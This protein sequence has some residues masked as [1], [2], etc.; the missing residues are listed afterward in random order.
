[1]FN[2][3]FLEYENLYNKTLEK[4]TQ[5]ILEETEA[6]PEDIILDLELLQSE[7]YYSYGFSNISYSRP[8]N[9]GEFFAKGGKVH[10]SL[11]LFT[12]ESAYGFIEWF[13][14]QT[15]RRI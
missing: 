15:R 10:Y 11:N 12:G 4:L 6:D 7:C 5:I 2:M 13:Y 9:I 1:M 14:R 3:N 8:A